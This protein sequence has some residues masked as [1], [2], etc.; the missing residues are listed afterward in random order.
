MKQILKRWKVMLST[1]ALLA[2]CL[3]FTA[4]AAEIQGEGDLPVL[5]VDGD[6]DNSG[7]NGDNVIP[8]AAPMDL[9]ELY[10]NKELIAEYNPSFEYT[11]SAI[12]PE[13]TLYMV[14][15]NEAGEEEK[16][17]FDSKY[18][19]VEYNNNI[20]VGKE[21]EIIVKA[22]EL[23]EDTEEVKYEGFFVANFE[24]TAKSLSDAKYTLAYTS[25]TY[26]GKDLKPA[27]TV[28]LTGKKL[29]NNTDY[30]VA[31]S[32]NKEVG[33][34]KVTVSGKGN[35]VGSKELTFK[36]ALAAPKLSTE[37]AYNKVTVKWGK[38]TGATKYVLERSTSK[39]KGFKKIAEITNGS[40]VKYVDKDVKLDKTYY[41]RLVAYRNSSKSAYSSVVSRKVKPGKAEITKISRASYTSLKITWKKVSGASRY[42]VYRSSSENGKY[43]RIATIKKASTLSYT[44]KKLT[45]GK[46]YYYKVRAYRKVN[47][48]NYYGAYSDMKSLNT[49]PATVKLDKDAISYNSTYITLK[50]KKASGAEGYEIYRSTSKNGEYTKVKTVSGASKLSYKNTG[51]DKKQKYYYKVRAYRKYNGKNVYGAFSDTYTK[52]PAGWRYSTYDGQ[53]V[54]YYYNAKGQKVKDVR[55]IIGK[56]DSYEI[57]VNKKKCAITVYAKDGDNGYII[58]VVAFICTTG[59]KTPVKTVKTPQKLRWA[60]LM[61]PSYGQ[62]STRISGSFLFHSVTYSSKKNNKLSVSAYNKLGTMCSHGCVRLTAGDAKWIYDNCPIG[63]TVKIYNSNKSGPFGKPKAHKLPYWHTWDPTDPTAKSRC[64]AN[65]CH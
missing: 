21:A 29:V 45:C 51:L 42:A 15:K 1:V 43:T 17:E 13:I 31:Y 60:T 39:T 54:K 22:K 14:N 41:Y 64:K 34:A 47:D 57:R 37:T 12:E 7:E 27:V 63:T 16:V 2:M 65:G 6:V 35:Y 46:T 9:S 4:F 36:I 30:T 44:D 62:W 40:T 11:G 55:N 5:L 28:E 52:H 58:P 56:Q 32:A 61:G 23:T 53:K 26:T 33:T 24:I 8:P 3:S 38:I 48:K 20:N 19:T 18:Y 59:A 25:A 10:E 50:W 49:Q